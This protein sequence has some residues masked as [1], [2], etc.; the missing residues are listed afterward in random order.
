MSDEDVGAAGAHLPAGTELSRTV[1]MTRRFK[2]PRERV[3]R[4]WAD[5]DELARWFPRRVEGGLALGARTVLVWPDIRVWWDVLESEPPR[6]WVFR[7]PWLVDER[8][9][10]T[11]RVTIEPAGYGSELV[12]EDGPFP[13]EQPGG[14]DAWAEALEGWG[15]A[16]AMLRAYVDFSVDIRPRL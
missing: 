11:V 12:L 8:I 7:W 14:L 9:I 15:E 10:T 4:A 16:L 2:A 13:L 6:T 1:H 3:F 5:P